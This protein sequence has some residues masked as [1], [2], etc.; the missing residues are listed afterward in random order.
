[1]TRTP[2]ARSKGLRLRSPGRF[3]HRRVGAS[4]GCSDGRGNVLAVGNCCYIA[5][6]GARRFGAHG[7]RRGTGHIASAARLQLVKF[8]L[9]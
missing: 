7:G 5:V 1:M 6:G 4:G 8:D 9:I 3:V 2:L